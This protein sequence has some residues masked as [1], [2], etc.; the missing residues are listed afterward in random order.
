MNL[1][2]SRDM[3]YVYRSFL[4]PEIWL[5]LVSSPE[6][7]RRYGYVFY[8]LRSDS[9]CSARATGVPY[10]AVL[11]MPDFRTAF[12]FSRCYAL[13]MSHLCHAARLGLPPGDSALHLALTSMDRTTAFSKIPSE[14]GCTAP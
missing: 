4:A 14:I 3:R 5:S 13:K 7:S 1:A 8:W 11:G 10:I 9:L 2:K 6:N 12:L